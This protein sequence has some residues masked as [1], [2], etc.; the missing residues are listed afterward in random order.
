M[1]TPVPSDRECDVIG[2][3]SSY[4]PGVP[5]LASAT[6][7]GIQLTSFVSLVHGNGS[8]QGFFTFSSSFGGIVFFVIALYRSYAGDSHLRPTILILRLEIEPVP[9]ARRGASVLAETASE[10]RD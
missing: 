6:S 4:P 9:F 3:C 5:I 8:N 1:A 10:A 7:P 2:A